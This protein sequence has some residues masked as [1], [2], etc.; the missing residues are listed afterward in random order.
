MPSVKINGITYDF[1]TLSNELKNHLKYLAFI[2]SEVE[3]LNLQLNVLRIS[4][5][6]IGRQLDSALL[7]QELNQS[8]PVGEASQNSL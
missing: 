8:Q 7:R 3:R 1:E 6:E 2:D 5:E 4:R